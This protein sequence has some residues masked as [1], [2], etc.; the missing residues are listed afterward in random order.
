MQFISR[1][2]AAMQPG[3]GYDLFRQSSYSARLGN[4]NVAIA[5]MF[6]AKFFKQW[7]PE[8]AIALEFDKLI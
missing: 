8:F 3:S 7:N 1:A 5:V 2:N 4:V 6:T